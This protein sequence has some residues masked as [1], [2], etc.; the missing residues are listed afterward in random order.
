M[1][2]RPFW[3]SDWLA[4]Q[5]EDLDVSLT[6]IITTLTYEVIHPFESGLL[7][8]GK[9]PKYIELLLYDEPSS[10]STLEDVVSVCSEP[11]MEETFHTGTS[12]KASSQAL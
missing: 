8:A 10:S 1:A 11:E 7:A 3:G 4:A 12:S 9:H 6:Q 2:G 5:K